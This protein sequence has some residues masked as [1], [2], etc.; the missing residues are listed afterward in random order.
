MSTAQELKIVFAGPMG[1]GK[2]TAIGAVSDLPPVSTE[3]VNN[4]QRAFAKEFTTVGLDF[5]QIEL[6][7]GT[8]VR[9]YGTPGQERF[10][11]MWEIIGAGAIGIILLLDASS[12]TAMSDLHAHAQVFRRVA[13][14]QPFVIGVGRVEAA[15]ERHVEACTRVL[16]ELGVSAPV[17]SVDVRKR[18]DVLL[19]IEALLA[20]LEARVSELAA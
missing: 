13:P 14:E 1:A 20:I 6:E 3:V 5:G 7:D 16:A 2:T 17:F 15:D 18:A 10:S 11:F 12:S 8:V 4:D 19:L 9:L